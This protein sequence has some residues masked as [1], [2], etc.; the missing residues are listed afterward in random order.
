M[1]ADV[2]QDLVVALMQSMDGSQ[3]NIHHPLLQN[4]PAESE[5]AECHHCDEDRIRQLTALVQECLH[6]DAESR[7]DPQY[8]CDRLQ[9][10]L[11]EGKLSPVAVDVPS[12]QEDLDTGT[13]EKGK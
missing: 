5:L 2:P 12:Q 1:N 13:G 4:M 6:W 8:L 7:P 3:E 11:E 10:W 9:E